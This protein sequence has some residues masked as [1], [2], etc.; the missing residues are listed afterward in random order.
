[1]NPKQTLMAAV[2]AGIGASL[3]C[4]APLLLLSLGIGGAWVAT[5]TAFE[6]LRPLFLGLATLFISLSFRKLYLTTPA[7]ETGKRCAD[8]DVIRKQRFIFWGVTIP[9]IGLLAFPWIA[10]FFY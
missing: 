8:E 5:L 10:P 1:M 2:L 6:P 9:L 4:V 7:C 3:C